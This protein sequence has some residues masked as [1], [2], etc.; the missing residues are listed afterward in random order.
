MQIIITGYKRVDTKAHRKMVSTVKNRASFFMRVIAVSLPSS[1]FCS[2]LDRVNI[3]KTDFIHQQV[4]LG[5][6]AGRAGRDKLQYFI[7]YQL[8]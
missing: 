4:A 6:I 8:N 3:L 1:R 2:S 5:S 7:H